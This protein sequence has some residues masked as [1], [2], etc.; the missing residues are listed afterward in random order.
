MLALLAQ[1]RRQNGSCGAA[2]L[3]WERAETPCEV[4]MVARGAALLCV[5]GTRVV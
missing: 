3:T 2:V 4:D 5:R 1:G